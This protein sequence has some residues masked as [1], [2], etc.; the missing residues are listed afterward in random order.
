MDPAACGAV[1]CGAVVW[2]T[3]G[4]A[5]RIRAVVAARAKRVIEGLLGRSSITA[6]LGEFTAAR[7]P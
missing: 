1:V 2:A 6:K 5:A 7:H 3:A 4:D